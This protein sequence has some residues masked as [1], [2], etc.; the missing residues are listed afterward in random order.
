VLASLVEQGA[1]SQADLGRILGLDRNNVNGIVTRLEAADL[2]KRRTDPDDRRRNI[3]TVTASGRAHFAMLQE[4]AG[5]VQNELLTGLTQ[6]EQRQ[7]VELLDRVLA[8]HP[9]LPA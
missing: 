3:V 7:L 9:T 8:A 1:L 6:A 4:H 2:I 5:I